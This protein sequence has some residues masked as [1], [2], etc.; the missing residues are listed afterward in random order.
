MKETD[1]SIQVAALCDA[2]KAVIQ[3]IAKAV[4]P[5]A[6]AFKAAE[7]E[8]QGRKCKDKRKRNRYFRKAKR[9]KRA[10]GL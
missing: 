6:A 3:G 1:I 7:L 5:I 10:Y 9:L 4:A 2:F 8:R